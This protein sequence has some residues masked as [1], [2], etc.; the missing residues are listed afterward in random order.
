MVILYH[1]LSSDLEKILKYQSEGVP[2][3]LS[4][5]FPLLSS[6]GA[7]RM[8]YVWVYF[9]YQVFT[10]EPTYMMT[11]MFTFYG[12]IFLYFLPYRQVTIYRVLRSQIIIPSI[13]SQKVLF[14]TS[15]LYHFFSAR[16]FRKANKK[17]GF[18]FKIIIFNSVFDTLPISLAYL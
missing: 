18:V 12:I 4:H 7:W 1:G 13:K 9:Q 6:F 14:K 16:S 17:S 10:W 15:G 5:I 11:Y 2:F 3:I 8:V